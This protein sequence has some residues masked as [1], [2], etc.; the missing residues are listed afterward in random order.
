MD[1]GMS[2][3][4]VTTPPSRILG[5]DPGLG[6]TGYA[7]LDLDPDGAEPK[8]RPQATANLRDLPLLVAITLRFA[9]YQMIRLMTRPSARVSVA[10]FV[11]NLRPGGRSQGEDT[12][13][14]SKE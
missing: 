12:L 10:A 3:K 4:T 1:H 8:L 11:R 13:G 2:A 14:V 6:L 9:W 7:C 5:I